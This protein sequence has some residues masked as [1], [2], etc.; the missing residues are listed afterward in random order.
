MSTTNL[1]IRNIHSSGVCF[2]IRT[3]APSNYV[4]RPSSGFLSVGES[5]EVVVT[6]N[7]KGELQDYQKHKFSIQTAPCSSPLSPDQVNNFWA[8]KPDDVKDVRLSVKC[9][10]PQFKT[11]SVYGSVLSEGKSDRSEAL[12]TEIKDLKEFHEKQENIKKKL[13]EEHRGI[14]DQLK[15]RDDEI[16][17]F[18]EEALKGF[19]TIHLVLASLLGILVGYIYGII[20]S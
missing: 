14:I 17:K 18:E 20:K 1:N 6:I 12:K 8:S 15:N 13:E 7:P 19:G 2:K 10:E 4:V 5:K 11:S 9:N 3:T 16:T